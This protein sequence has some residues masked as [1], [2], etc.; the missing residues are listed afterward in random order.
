MCCI[1]LPYARWARNNALYLIKSL[2]PASPQAGEPFQHAYSGRLLRWPPSA[3]RQSTKPL[4]PKKGISADQSSSIANGGNHDTTLLVHGRMHANL[5]VR[6]LPTDLDEGTLQQLFQSFGALECCRVVREAASGKSCG[7]GFVKFS[8][9]SSAGA[10]VKGLNG[11]R[12]SSNT[13]Q[14]KFA[15]MDA[16]PSPIGKHIIIFINIPLELIRQRGPCSV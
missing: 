11:A 6:N 5:Y 10:A 1:F 4:C 13:L 2:T 15:D 16:G 7:Y 3:L 9:V 12:L 14:V 8:C